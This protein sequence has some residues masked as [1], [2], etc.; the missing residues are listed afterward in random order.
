MEG[1]TIYSGKTRDTDV[2]GAL[3]VGDR[4]MEMALL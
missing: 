1:G 4:R 2:E 3:M